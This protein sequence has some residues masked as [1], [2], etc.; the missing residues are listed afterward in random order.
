MEVEGR[1]DTWKNKVEKINNN[2]KKKKEEE[3]K[4]EKWVS[5]VN[6]KSSGAQWS[7][8]EPYGVT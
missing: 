6:I 7:V 3:R 4:K 5:G 1:D 8:V 2:K